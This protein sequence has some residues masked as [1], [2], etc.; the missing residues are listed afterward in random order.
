MAWL[1]DASVLPVG[2]VSLVAGAAHW[3]GT[4]LSETDFPVVSAAVGLGSRVQFGVSVPRVLASAD[5]TGAAGGLGTSYISS[6]I[7]CLTGGSGVKLAVSPMIQIL[8]EGA[9]QAL[10]AGESRVQFGLPVSL[11]VSQGIARVFASTGFFSRDLGFHTL[12]PRG[13]GLLERVGQNEPTKVTQVTGG[14]A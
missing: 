13:T 11:E 14:S 9:V 5:G 6:K 2:A 10:P 1:D 7:A 3:S 8:G 12:S 4:D